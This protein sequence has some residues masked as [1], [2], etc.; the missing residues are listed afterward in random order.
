VAEIVSLNDELF[1][2]VNGD[3][4]AALEERMALSIAGADPCG[5]YTCSGFGPCSGFSCGTFKIV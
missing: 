2:L 4:L 5:V 1:S 3:P